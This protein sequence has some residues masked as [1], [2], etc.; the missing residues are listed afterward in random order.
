VRN[1]PI[2][3]QLDRGPLFLERAHRIRDLDA[4]AAILDQ[5]RNLPAGSIA[6]VYELLPTIL[7]EFPSG[8]SNGTR[9]VHLLPRDEAIRAKQEGR[10]IMATEDAADKER[11]I[12]G[13]TMKEIGAHRLSTS[14][15]SHTLWF[16]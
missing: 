14:R 1:R 16:E 15:N 6:I 3:L 4:R 10:V 9:F 13:V 5:T 12:Y 11:E 7:W 8:V 2:T